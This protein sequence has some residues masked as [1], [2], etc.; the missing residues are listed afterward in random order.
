MTLSCVQDEISY[1]LILHTRKCHANAFTKGWI[2]LK[3]CMDMTLG[4]DEDLIRF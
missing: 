2:G 3:F 1:H 4:H